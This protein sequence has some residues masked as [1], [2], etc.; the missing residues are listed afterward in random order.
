MKSFFLRCVSSCVEIARARALSFLNGCRFFGDFCGA[1]P[2]LF[3]NIFRGDAPSQ[4]YAQGHIHHDPHSGV[5]SLAD[6]CI[7]HVSFFPLSSLL[8]YAPSYSLTY[9]PS[10]KIL[11]SFFDRDVY[12][13]P[14]CKLNR[15]FSCIPV[16]VVSHVHSVKRWQSTIALVV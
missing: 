10:N 8:E 11:L 12:K 13:T 14:F 4:L 15:I 2:L 3:L 5:L 6:G 1:Q 16:I 7:P 9:T